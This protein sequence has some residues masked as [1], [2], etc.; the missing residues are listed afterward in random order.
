M[1]AML[2]ELVEKY[3]CW[4]FGSIL[5]R[6]LHMLCGHVRICSCAGAALLSSAGLLMAFGGRA[7]DL[8]RFVESSTTRVAG[9]ELVLARMRERR[10]GGSPSSWLIDSRP[11]RRFTRIA[12]RKYETLCN[13]LLPH[14][15]TNLEL[16]FGGN[17]CPE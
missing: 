14:S 7:K 5:G 15:F 9:W 11:R 8:K 12:F 17:I 10:V 16:P 13:F 2:S 1:N 6:L 3:A 4:I